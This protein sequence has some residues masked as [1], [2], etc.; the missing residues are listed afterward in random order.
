LKRLSVLFIIFLLLAGCSETITREYLLEGNWVAISGYKN[1]EVE[2]EPKCNLIKGLN[3]KDEETVYVD[4]IEQDF[5]YTISDETEGRLELFSERLN[6]LMR[7]DTTIIDED[8][9]VIEGA[10]SFDDQV[11]YMERQ[12]D[13]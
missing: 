9:M 4:H 8:G 5:E 7:L 2:G 3:F 6:M 11:C 13:E 12:T 1:G 10:F